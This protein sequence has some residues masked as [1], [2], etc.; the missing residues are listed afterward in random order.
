[1]DFLSEIS[2]KVANYWY[3]TVTEQSQSDY[4]LF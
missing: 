3:N 2:K 1:M 4:G